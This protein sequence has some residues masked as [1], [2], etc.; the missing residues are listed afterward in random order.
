M[1]TPQVKRF[2]TPPGFTSSHTKGSQTIVFT[3][4]E[5]FLTPALEVAA[6]HYAH[7]EPI[8]AF[9]SLKRLVQI[10]HWRNSLAIEDEIELINNGPR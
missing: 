3:S 2:H 6:V 10:S 1:P 4:K 8:I 7:P 9:K 5:A